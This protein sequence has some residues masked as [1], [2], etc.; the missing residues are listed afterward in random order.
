[1]SGFRANPRT[2]HLER[3]KRIIGYCM[4]FKHAAIR[5]RTKCPDY[6]SLPDDW[7]MTPYSN[8]KE[9][10]PHNCPEPLGK[11][12]ITTTWVDAN[13]YHDFLTGRSVTGNWRYS[14][15]QPNHN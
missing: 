1:M 9:E 4:K 13:L 8:V 6:S 15:G 3:V 12:V 7:D 11:P 14:Y 10:I 5:Y 2:G